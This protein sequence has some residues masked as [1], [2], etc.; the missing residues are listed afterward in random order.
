MI[1]FWVI[2]DPK[3]VHFHVKKTLK[4]QLLYDVVYTY[5][6]HRRIVPASN[7]TASNQVIFVGGSF[8][9][10]EG[11]NDHETIPNYFALAQNHLSKVE[12]I[13]C[14][15][16]GTH[17]VLEIVKNQIVTD[18]SF[19]GKP[20]SLIYVFMEDHIRRAAGRSAWDTKGPWY[21]VDRGVLH[22]CGNFSQKPIQIKAENKISLTTMWEHTHFYHRFFN[23]ELFISDEDM[24]RAALM[25]KEMNNLL[26]SKKIDFKVLMISSQDTFHLSPI[27]EQGGLD[28]NQVIYLPFKKSDRD[29]YRIKYDGHTTAVFNEKTGR[30]L[31]RILSK[32]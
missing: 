6:N 12:N 22:K 13:S 9:F 5:K 2:R 1:Q 8:C 7:D 24:T 28:P 25:F 32:P 10:G 31:Q 16:Y 14:H 4:D 15:G 29:D 19:M 11:V 3:E 21:E 18:S 30:Y 20:T 23:D 27:I 26:T 17:Q